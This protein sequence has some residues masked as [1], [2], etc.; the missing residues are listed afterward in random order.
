MSRR[1]IPSRRFS[2][3][4]LP[5]ILGT[6]LAYGSWSYRNPHANDSSRATPWPRTSQLSTQQKQLSNTARSENHPSHEVA[7]HRST[8]SSDDDIPLFEAD[9]DS[10]SWASLSGKVAYAHDALNAI[11]WSKFGDEIVDL[12]LPTWAAGLPAFFSKLQRE[13]EMAPGS[14]AE[15]I[16]QEAQDPMFNPEIARIARVRISKDL[17]SEEI[18]FRGKR[19]QYTTRALAKYL[20]IPEAEVD[21]EDVPII[22][23]CG[24]GGGLRALVAGTSSYHSAQ[25][26]GLYD[27]VTY[28]AGVSGS[29]WLQALYY[30]TIGKQ[31]FSTLL[32]HL[33][34]RIGT[35]I[36]YPPDALD[37][38]TSAPTNK[39]L[40]SGIVE[41]V[42][43]DPSAE[44]GLVD[45]YGILLAARLLV[46]KGELGVDDRNLKVSNQRSYLKDGAHPLPIYTAVRH[47]IPVEEEDSSKAKGRKAVPPVEADQVRQKAWFQWFESTPYELYSEALEAGIPSWSVGR[48]FDRG[49][50]A[51]RD[52]GYSVPELRL[53]FFLGIWGSAFC[54]TLSHY[55]KEIRPIF[56]GLVG[57][58][59]IDDL[60]SDRND[61]LV[62]VHP[63]EPA[64]IP[65][66]VLGLENQLPP[67]SAKTI[68]KSEHLEL[69]DAGMSNNLPIYPLL[70][71]GRNV[72]VLIAF[73]ASADIKTENWL[74]V[75]DEY[76]RNKNVKGWP[77]G[78]GWP[79]EQG[80]DEEEPERDEQEA[81]EGDPNTEDN[82]KRTTTATQNDLTYCNTWVGNTS[83][84]STIPSSS[85]DDSSSPSSSPS[86]YQPP[87]TPATLPTHL[88]SPTAGLALIYFPFLPNPEV[89]G[90]DPEK[91]DFMSTWNFIYTPDDIEKVVSLA[92]A[93]FRQGE[94]Q[95]KA[96]VRA[97]YERKKR[98][99]VEREGKERRGRWKGR[100]RREGDHFV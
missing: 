44:F 91:S 29:C 96:V 17:C 6:S 32:K 93:N 36:A 94:E 5:V 38:L 67:T 45:A 79:K 19:K 74:S 99:R 69:A 80:G 31:N 4:L 10:G 76:A 90:V 21:P 51:V 68:F 22:A 23:I 98:G 7:S 3:G 81:Q 62:K 35:H 26:A 77:A 27:C 57:Y 25:E 78:A 15:E 61:D 37:L 9:P 47:E 11:R 33:K 48:P 92:R 75:A 30:S 73:D 63:I 39:F 100:L 56:K 34:Q 66:Y 40:L 52:N 50:G 59:G 20:G 1:I 87:L 18:L 70:R 53:P 2:R 89:A 65:N 49:I 83:P 54:A 88:S 64:A 71:P 12:I 14:L 84:Q 58:E 8:A 82:S 24:S 72:D 55:Y 42:K 16:W 13:L 95:V 97:V 28:T 43:G 46:P 86:T 60:L 85:S 41:K